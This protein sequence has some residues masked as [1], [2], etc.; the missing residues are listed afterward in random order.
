[1]AAAGQLL[2][3]ALPLPPSPGAGN[4]TRAAKK[5]APSKPAVPFVDPAKPPAG[6]Q[7]LRCNVTDVGKQARSHSCYQG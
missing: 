2:Q 5:E 6:S 3:P 1:M 4:A 7:I